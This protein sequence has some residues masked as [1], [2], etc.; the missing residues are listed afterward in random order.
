MSAKT[1][2]LS[3]LATSLYDIDGTDL[4][5]RYLFPEDDRLHRHMEYLWGLEIYTIDPAHERSILRIR[6]SMETPFADGKGDWTLAPTEETLRAMQ[7]L[8]KHNFTVPVTER[9][10]FL[11]EFAAQEYE[12]IFV[13]INTELDFLVLETGRAPQRFS[14]PYIDLP[15]VKSSANPFFV[16]FYSRMKIRMTNPFVTDAVSRALGDLTIYWLGGFP[17][18]KEFLKICYPSTRITLSDDD[19]DS[20]SKTRFAGSGSTFGEVVTLPPAQFYGPP[21]RKFVRKTPP[22]EDGVLDKDEFIYDWG[23]F[24][25]ASI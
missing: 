25:S 10:S 5:S 11:A 22:E 24:F 15:R 12:Y 17:L 19:L 20:E 7:L 1:V 23:A 2:P 14:A 9:K 4:R 21:P 18:P 6:K 13:P 3:A 16:T 8:Q